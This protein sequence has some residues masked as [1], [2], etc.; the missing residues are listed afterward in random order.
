MTWTKCADYT[1]C[2]GFFFG[3]A[4]SSLGV[5]NKVSIYP[6][7]ELRSPEPKEILP[8]KL[9]F[10]HKCDRCMRKPGLLVTFEEIEVFKLTEV[11]SM[12]TE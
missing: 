4:T 1:Q 2:F 7:Q 8:T 10:W 12:Q 5:R 11:M 6:P 9:T 3:S